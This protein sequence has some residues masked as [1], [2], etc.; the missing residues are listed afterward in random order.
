MEVKLVL[1]SSSTSSFFLLCYLR[2][3]RLRFLFFFFFAFIHVF[4]I[5]IILLL[6]LLLLPPFFFFMLALLLL[7]FFNIY[8]FLFLQTLTNAHHRRLSVAYISIA[9]IHWAPTGATTITAVR[10]RNQWIIFFFLISDRSIKFIWS[11]TKREMQRI[12][13]K[14]TFII[15]EI[16]RL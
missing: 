7:L 11:K 15:E 5:I 4:I 1:S 3:H 13:V 9:S 2:C 8:R 14:I 10:V 16:I 6:L 12:T